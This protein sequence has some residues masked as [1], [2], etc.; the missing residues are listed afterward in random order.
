M[1]DTRVSHK[2]FNRAKQ[3]IPGGQIL[4]LEPRAVGGEPIFFSQ[5]RG[6]NSQISMATPIS[7]ILDRGTND[8]RTPPSTSCCSH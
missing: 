1:T 6:P 3:L 8:P 2:A 5:G 4:L 7:I